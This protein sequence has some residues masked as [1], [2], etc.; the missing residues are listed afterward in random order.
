[1]TQAATS[2]QNAVTVMQAATVELQNGASGTSDSDIDGVIQ[3]ITGEGPA[4]AAPLDAASQ[5]L[6]AALGSQPAPSPADV[7]AALQTLHRA[8]LKR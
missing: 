3:T 7:T 6:S 2:V 1:M 4:I 8:N 5:T